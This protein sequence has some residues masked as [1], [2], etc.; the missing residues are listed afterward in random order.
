MAG[1]F[2]RLKEGLAKTRD[3]LLKGF[4][5]VFSASEID[6]DFYEELEETLILADIGVHA[7]DQILMRI[8]E[9]VKEK[10]IK[11]P[12]ECKALLMEQIRVQMAVKDTDY[13]FEEGP[14]VIFVIGVN[15]VGKTTS[16]G[17]LAH[18]YKRAGKKVIIAAADTFRAAATEQL[19]EWAKRA[20][21]EIVTGR[22]GADPG[23]VFYDA[24]AK[25][26]REKADILICDTA[27]RLHN[28]RNLMDELAK[29]DR[30]L[31]KEYPEA[32]RENLIVLDAA[33]GQN[34]LQQA[35]DFGEVTRLTGIILTKMDGTA[36][37]GIAIAIQSE[38]SVPV[39]YIGV[40]EKIDDLERFDPIQF[41][42]ALL[43]DWDENITSKS[44][45]EQ[46]EES[47]T[48]E[49]ERQKEE[50][51]TEEESREEAISAFDAGGME[52]SGDIV[53]VMSTTDISKSQSSSVNEIQDSI[54]YNPIDNQLAASD[55]SA[56]SEEIRWSC[57][58][59]MST[60]YALNRK[61][62]DKVMSTSGILR[63]Q[64]VSASK[65]QDSIDSKIFTSDFSIGS[66]TSQQSHSDIMSTDAAYDNKQDG[67]VRSASD[68]A[69]GDES[70]A[71]NQPRPTDVADI[72]TPATDFSAA[73]D[74]S[75][76]GNIM[77]TENDTLEERGFNEVS[78][79]AKLSQDNEGEI[80][81]SLIPAEENY[82]TIDSTATVGSMDKQTEGVMS[83]Q[84]AVADESVSEAQVSPEG[85][86]EAVPQ[87]A[88]PQEAASQE[89][90]P[91]EEALQ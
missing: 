52:S 59:I 90:A 78:A 9:E 35:K 3:N 46:K 14:S 79:D 89:P 65:I 87:E 16:V 36:K 54:A 86:Q 49:E 26:K 62:D 43:S 25:A 76:P 33:T 39:K 2:E 8:K 82:K 20:S 38:L 24:V 48:E 85:Y 71:Q 88:A 42:D 34:A 17:K 22:E 61:Q 84:A 60:D 83:T 44:A 56:Y 41:S 66:E 50:R 81:K 5:Q 12:E 75:T 37:G 7:T 70:I 27:G 18:K 73:E 31:S 63:S 40:G 74:Q 77:S 91:Q 72:E 19:T 6:E 53:D 55:F 57:S 32:Y 13:S 1:F 64:N 10:N 15:G 4:A 23:S 29:L 11:H 80:L 30:I 69:L 45:K 21:C 58:D 68:M 67:K 51:Q 47:Q 28:K